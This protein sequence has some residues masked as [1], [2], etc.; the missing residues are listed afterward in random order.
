MKWALGYRSA[1]T[2]TPEVA[3]EQIKAKV[4][5][6]LGRLDDF[7]PYTIPQ[8]MTLDLTYRQARPAELISLLPIVDRVDA[9]TVRFEAHDI[10]ELSRF[11]VFATSYNA[12]ASP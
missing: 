7:K 6:A 8:P 2:L 1:R 11:L 5:A 4:R 3:R 10:G 9:F 12:K